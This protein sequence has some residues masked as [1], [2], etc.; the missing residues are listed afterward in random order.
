MNRPRPSRGSRISRFSPRPLARPRGRRL[1]LEALEERQLL[2]LSPQLVADLNSLV[3][4]DGSS[5]SNFCQVGSSLYFSATSTTTGS[6]LWEMDG[7]TGDTTIVKD[8]CPGTGSSSP[9]NLVNVGGTLYWI[10]VARRPS[11]RPKRPA[12]GCDRPSKSWPPCGGA[13][14]T[15]WAEWDCPRSFRP[16]RCGSWHPP[17]AA[18]GR[19]KSV[20]SDCVRNPSSVSASKRDSAVACDGRPR[21]SASA[22]LQ[23]TVG[24]VQV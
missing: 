4:S 11:R 10:L 14:A 15:L 23:G 12:S 2:S 6:E 22:E 3:K 17:R 16:S 18:S 19:F 20:C 24:D 21:T 13:G 7:T 1:Q 8:I 9:L 5:P